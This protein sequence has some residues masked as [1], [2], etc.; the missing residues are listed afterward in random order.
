MKDGVKAERILTAIGSPRSSTCGEV[1]LWIVPANSTKADEAA[2]YSELLREA[3]TNEYT[4][5]RVE[6]SGNE[7][8]RDNA[9]RKQFVQ[10]EGDV[11]SLKLLDQAKNFSSQGR[12]RS[13]SMMSR[14]GW[15]ERKTRRS[16]DLF[17]RTAPPLRR[18]GTRLRRAAA[19]VL[20]IMHAEASYRRNRDASD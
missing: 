3:E 8:I 13:R 10:G 16:H 15:I 1:R 6:F 7:Q 5:R 18:S 20:V 19:T 17:S 11:L 4:L 2:Y 12:Y 9:L 14:R